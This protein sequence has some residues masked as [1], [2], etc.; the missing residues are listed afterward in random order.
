MISINNSH[1]FIEQSMT[2]F[3]ESADYLRAH[4]GVD[5]YVDED[6]WGKLK[7]LLGYERD[8]DLK[9]LDKVESIDEIKDAFVVV[10]SS[11]GYVELPELRAK[12]PYFIWD[13]PSSW[14]KVKVINESYLEIYGEYDTTIY[15]VP[16]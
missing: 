15:Y 9:W 7:F 3:K 13:P 12:L 2:D 16:P 11:R 5:I 6:T 10:D 1:F 14:I 8:E 4:P